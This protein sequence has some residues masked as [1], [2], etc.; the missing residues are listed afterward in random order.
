MRS[1]VRRPSPPRQPS[2]PRRHDTSS[3]FSPRGGADLSLHYLSKL[4][5]LVIR[6]VERDDIESI[7]K[8]LGCKPVAHIDSF[9]ADKLGSADLVEEVSVGGST[10]V[11]KI[12]GVKYPG[13]TV[14]LLVRGSNR[15]V[16]DETDRSLH[17]AL[18]VV[19]SLIRKR[20]LIAGGG[21]PE[22][23]VARQLTDWSKTLT[24]MHAVCVR[25]FAEVRPGKWRGR[26][27]GFRHRARISFD[28]RPSILAGHGDRPLHPGGER[29]HESHRHR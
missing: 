15:L 20:F 1:T 5:I 2:A 9:T 12:T 25:A 10:K 23:E 3:P 14:S 29:G 16:L 26:G 7:A 8:T 13:Q 22:I 6:D 11:T 18:C 28:P 24:G 4:K 19:R 17:D 21:A 27:G